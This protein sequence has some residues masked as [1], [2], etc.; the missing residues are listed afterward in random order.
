VPEVALEE[1]GVERKDAL[2]EPHVDRSLTVVPVERV[3]T[4][5]GKSKVSRNVSSILSYLPALLQLF[6]ELSHVGAFG[7]KGFIS[8]LIEK[9]EFY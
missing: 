2:V 8:K 3:C 7:Y 5:S 9:T 1:A 6:F 4:L